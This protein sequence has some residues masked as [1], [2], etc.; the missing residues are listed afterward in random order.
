MKKILNFLFV[1]LAFAVLNVATAEAQISPGHPCYDIDPSIDGRDGH[2]CWP[3][4][5]DP[6]VSVEASGE[7]DVKDETQG[8][9]SDTGKRHKGIDVSGEKDNNKNKV[10]E[11]GMQGMGRNTTNC[12]EGVNCKD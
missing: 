10:G 8:L 11:R 5:E 6:S 2:A 3:K 12:A 9:Y 7:R 4:G 1:G